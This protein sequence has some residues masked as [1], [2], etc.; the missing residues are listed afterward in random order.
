V[1]STCADCEAGKYKADTGATACN[2]CEA[3]KHKAA[4][5]INTACGNKTPQNRVATRAGHTLTLA[6][7]DDGYLLFFQKQI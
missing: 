7:D 3:G 4:A 2:I 5:G 1:A 6:H